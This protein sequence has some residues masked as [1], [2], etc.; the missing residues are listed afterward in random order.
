LR[1]P[2]FEGEW[3]EV[4]LGELGD[5][6]GGGTPSSSNT[7]FW[8]GTVPWISSSDLNENDIH[9][10]NITRF[11]TEEAISNSSTKL[12]TAPVILIVSRVGVG[13]LAYSEE[14]LCTS[15]DF[16]NITNLRCNGLFLSYLLS[17]TMRKAS[18]STQG[19]SIKGITSSEIKSK[20]IFIPKLAEQKKIAEFISLID[21]R[22]RTQNKIIK[23]LELLKSTISKKIFRQQARFK[24]DHRKK[25]PDW[26]IQ[27]LGELGKTYNGLSGKTKENFGT[28][29]KYIQYKQIFDSSKIQLDKCG[30]VEVSKDEDQNQVQ[31]GDIFFTISSET[32]EEIGMSSVLLDKVGEVYLNSFCFGYRPN[33]LNIL[34]PVFSRYLFRSDSFRSNIIK[35]AQGSTRYNMSKLELMKLRVSIPSIEE[36][37]LIANFL[38]L[39]D[40]K[41]TAENRLLGF[42]EIQKKYLLQNLFI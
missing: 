4:L 26:R 6:S 8:S 29:K 18:S 20:K 5:F 13:K 21:D 30:L 36:Q 22:I 39:I 42:Y 33:S 10:I 17:T 14:S 38:L 25:Y 2:S 28:G 34:N 37:I 24:A 27:E 23:E 3:K 16:T 12:C 1:F 32:P 11:I 41:I 15:Q 9:S 31:Y 19:T 7:S 35:L 40:E